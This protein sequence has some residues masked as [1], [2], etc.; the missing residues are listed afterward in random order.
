MLAALLVLVITAAQPQPQ[1][2]TANANEALWEAARLGDVARVTQALD[3]GADINAKTRYGVTALS[4][5]ADKGHLAVVTLLIQRGAEINVQD[6]FY[7]ARPIDWALGN[8]HPDVALLLLE[9]GSKGAGDALDVAVQM[10]HAALAKA[11]LAAPDL[12][13]ANLNAALAAAK[14]NNKAPMIELIAAKLATMPP[15]TTP[16]VTVERRV[17]E[18]YAGRYRN[19]QNGV[20]VAITLNGDR[21]TA[22]VPNQPPLSLVPTSPTEFKV[23]EQDGL[24][25]AFAGRGGMIEVALVTEN[26]NTRAYER[27][28]PGAGTSGAPASGETSTK[29]ATPAGTPSGA[30]GA[31]PSSAPA[32]SIVRTAARPWPAFRGDNAS[33]NGDGQG[34][35]AD[36]NLD[37][38]N[39]VRWKTPIPGISNSSPIVWGSRVFVVSAVSSAGDKT[40]KTGL[41]GDV[42]PVNDLSEHT[43]TIYCLDRATGAITWQRN[44]FTGLPKVKR[45]T[46]A[47][48]ANATPVTDGKTVV[49]LFGS[50]GLLAA[51]DMEGKPRWT[52]DVGVLN[53]GWFFDPDYQWGHASSPIIYKNTVI[54]QADV[55]KGSFLAAYDLTSGKMAWRT[56]RDEIPTWGTPTLFR[57]DGREQIVTNGPK[58]RGYDPATG[59]L[60]WTLGPNSEVTVGT[61]VVGD[62]L[63]YVTGGYPPV[64]PIYAIKPT[65][66]GT[67]TLAKDQPANDALAWSNDREGTYIPTPLYYDGILYTCGNNGVLTA[68]DGKTGERLY[69]SRVGGGGGAFTASPVAADGRLYLTTEEGEVY[70]VRAGRAYEEIAKNEMKEV[71]MSTPAVSDGLIIVRTLGHV[72]GLGE[73]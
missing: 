14:S 15:D 20:T 50:I 5:A 48:Q 44:A 9:K 68:Y 64:R 24:T 28:L 17:L 16:V 29:S 25:V 38:G 53:S 2:A 71:V 43:W 30:S 57:A 26:G 46:K 36:W 33:G 40:F 69:R 54:V 27:L 37:T 6:G 23:A 8:K 18:S 67:I 22:T 31:T 34:A 60:L 62:G 73:K 65:A 70:V 58:I 55:Q 41:Y 11:A 51:W 72:Y 3:A 21:L 7:R 39:N 1:A 52:A 63:V 49:A 56:D 59:K 61:P 42:A 13:R 32:R 47:S 4:F 12:T 35:V 66:A 45:H 10:D 19:D